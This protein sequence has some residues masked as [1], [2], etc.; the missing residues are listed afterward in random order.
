MNVNSFQKKCEEKYD[1]IKTMSK[2]KDIYIWG[3]GQ[4][5]SI[6]YPILKEH[7]IEVKGFIDSFAR[8]NQFFCRKKYMGLKF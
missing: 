5:A 7:H 6:L 1:L 8:K 2:R 4:G 3:I